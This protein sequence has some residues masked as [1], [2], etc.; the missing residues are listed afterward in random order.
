ML[1]LKKIAITGG[2]ASGKSTVCRLFKELGALVVSSDEV[3]HELLQTDPHLKQEVLRLFG[4]EV[5]QEGS[6][7]RK[8]IAE[9]VFKDPDL[10]KALE[11]MLHPAVLKQIENLYE[12]ARKSGK[13]RLFVVEVPLLYEIRGESFYD[14]VVVVVTDEQKA[15][16][17]FQQAGF[18][19]EE[20]DRR[21][22][23][24]LSPQEKTARADY[25]LHNNGSI[26]DLKRQVTALNQTLIGSIPFHES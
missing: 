5:L 11:A 8:K 6:L 17:R 24:Q 21:M 7:S 10:L 23:R 15:S 4:S 9:H 16:H 18:Q 25:I 1:A 14:K 20:Y 22:K 2:I 26:D 13:H 12:A 3:V 19:K